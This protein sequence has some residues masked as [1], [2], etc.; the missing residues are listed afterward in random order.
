VNKIQ[1][2]VL[3][4]NFFSI[5]VPASYSQLTTNTNITNSEQLST[6]PP[7]LN[8]N[9]I[10][11]KNNIIGTLTDDR[12]IGTAGTDVIIGLPGSDNIRGG[13]GTDIIQGDEDADR[14][15]GENDNDIIQGGLGS[16]QI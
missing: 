2:V 1:I 6:S 3:L 16:D 15:Y 12:I 5:C 10:N 11:L 14:L 4:L 7:P 8:S 13:N 9:E